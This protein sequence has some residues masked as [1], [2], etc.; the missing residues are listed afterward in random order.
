MADLVE[1]DKLIEIRARRPPRLGEVFSRP[2]LEGKRL[3]GDLEIHTNGIRYQGQIRSEQRIGK[4]FFF[5][6]ILKSNI[7][8]KLKTF[9]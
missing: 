1:Q 5:N 3:P 7:T 2:A 6:I 8:L 4:F 9:N